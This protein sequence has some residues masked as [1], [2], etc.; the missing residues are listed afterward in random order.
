LR[1][2]FIFWRTRRDARQ[3]M[4][5]LGIW[6]TGERRH[7]SS[8]WFHPRL[9]A[10]TNSNERMLG[11]LA[12]LV[13]GIGMVLIGKFMVGLG[14]D[15]EFIVDGGML[16][17]MLTPILVGF[18]PRII[19]NLFSRRSFRSDVR[20]MSEAV[21]VIQR[22]TVDRGMVHGFFSY[23][24]G[25]LGK[26]VRD[27]QKKVKRLSRAV[28]RKIDKIGEEAEEKWRSI[29]DKL[30][31]FRDKLIPELSTRVVDLRKKGWAAP[32]GDSTLV[33]WDE[34]LSFVIDRVEEFEQEISAMALQIEG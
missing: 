30:I 18:V 5:K 17:W 8:P 16:C 23:N 22:M 32:I 13:A 6:S 27:L 3:R 33:D 10:S 21:D 19:S 4:C 1:C 20:K 2:R 7:C 29:A 28:S 14:I 26:L 34:G 11:G 12:G 25:D 15:R 24:L 9:T 31:A